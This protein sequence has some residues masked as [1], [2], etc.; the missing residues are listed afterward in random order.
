[1]AALIGTMLLVG[2]PAIFGDGVIPAW[3]RVSVDGGLLLQIFPPAIQLGG[4]RLKGAPYYTSTGRDLTGRWLASRRA[5]SRP[6]RPQ[7]FLGSEAAGE[8]VPAEVRRSRPR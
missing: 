4:G 3:G 1:M 5:M 6:G 2:P 7:G 8:A